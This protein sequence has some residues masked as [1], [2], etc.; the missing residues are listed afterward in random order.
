RKLPGVVR[1]DEAAPL[2]VL[3]QRTPRL[4]IRHRDPRPVRGLN[5]KAA[6]PPPT[7]IAYGPHLGGVDAYAPNE[8]LGPW[9]RWS[10]GKEDPD[11]EADVLGEVRPQLLSRSHG[12]DIARLAHDH[13]GPV[14]TFYQVQ[15]L[16]GARRGITVASGRHD[17][18][19]TATQDRFV[20]ERI[21]PR[22]LDLER[23]DGSARGHGVCSEGAHR[24]AGRSSIA[25]L[26]VRGP[27]LVE[28]KDR[29]PLAPKWRIVEGTLLM[30]QPATR[31]RGHRI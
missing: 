29:P 7:P 6:R 26:W 18:V 4:G 5:A 31:T 27:A 23:S 2:S 3:G 15:T 10:S 24:A 16:T 30:L 22:S 1:A 21:I 12:G 14:G 13:T 25:Q 20:P 19:I 8:P 11:R 17:L 28:G 9:G